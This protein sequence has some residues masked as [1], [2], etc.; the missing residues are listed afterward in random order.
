MIIKGINHPLKVQKR[1][2]K[3]FVF[4]MGLPITRDLGFV[5]VYRYLFFVIKFSHISQ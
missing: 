3:I 4:F 2:C 5:Y 1:D